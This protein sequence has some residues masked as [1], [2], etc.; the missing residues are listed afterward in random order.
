MAQLYQPHA[1]TGC[2]ALLAIVILAFYLLLYPYR[3]CWISSHIPVWFHLLSRSFQIAPSIRLVCACL[4]RAIHPKT[5]CFLSRSC[6]DVPTRLA[7][8]ASCRGGGCCAA[9]H[10]LV[11]PLHISSACIAL[12]AALLLILT[13]MQTHTLLQPAASRPVVSSP[14]A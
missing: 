13:T 5:A 7:S 3:G 10:F 11:K 1:L 6:R 12:H 14:R 2:K 8:S 4:L 9:N